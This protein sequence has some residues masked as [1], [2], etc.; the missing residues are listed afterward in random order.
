MLRPEVRTLAEL[1]R[2]R[3]F[4][5]GGAVSTFLLR[6]ETGVAQGF[7]FFDGRFPD[8][9]AAVERAGDATAKTALA[10]LD[11]QSGQRF[12]MFVEAPRDGADG[13]VASVVARLKEREIYDAATIFVVGGRGSTQCRRP[14]R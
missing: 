10:W 8:T 4:A 2:N 14:A 5:T 3:G 7:S 12:F 6:S 1:L 9:E 11:S 13:V